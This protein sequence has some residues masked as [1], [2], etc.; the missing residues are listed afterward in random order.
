M[1]VN[2]NT[3]LMISHAWQQKYTLIISI[4]NTHLT[5]LK[6]RVPCILG[7]KEYLI[8]LHGH[9]KD[10]T[11]PVCQFILCLEAGGYESAHISL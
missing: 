10:T 11:C 7:W 3:N 8:F 1:K 4:K 6:I 9:N 2:S 5:F